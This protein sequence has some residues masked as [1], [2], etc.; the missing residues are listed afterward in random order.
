MA[1]VDKSTGGG[2]WTVAEN[3]ITNAAFNR[4]VQLKYIPTSITGSI[5]ERLLFTAK[6]Y[7]HILAALLREKYDI[8]HIHMAEKGSVYR[9]AIVLCF[10]KFF[11]C[12]VVLHMHGAEFEDWYRRSGNLNQYLV[13]K[14]I[15]KADKVIILGR[16]WETFM[17]SLLTDSSRKLAVVYNAVDVP[18]Q[19]LY[20]PDAKILLFLGV[21]GQRKGILD[22]LT[23][24]KD[25]DP[26]LDDKIILWI[27]GP[28][29]INIT[30]RIRHMGLCHRA[31]YKGWINTEEKA[32]VFRSAS[33]NILPSYNEG[34]P[35][36][37]LET[38]AYGIP[39]IA[40]GIAAIPE[41]VT[42]ENGILIQAGNTKSLRNAILS[43]SVD[44]EK[45]IHKSINAYETIK[46][47]FSLDKHFAQILQIYSELEKMK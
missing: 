14:I 24:L 11:R 31:V 3:Y 35:M 45:R 25:A 12:K 27:C 46:K 17:K 41:A 8:V 6:A 47:H 38:M 26:Y 4:S 40:T 29:K 13:R 32:D 7:L 43:L 9:K 20:N 21:A 36:S 22:L 44:R 1:G 28:D 19:R 2:M 5:P 10:A 37:I 33:V 34:L 15:N 16:Y 23:A 30:D 39:N 18:A 42:E